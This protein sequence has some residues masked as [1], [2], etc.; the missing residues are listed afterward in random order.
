MESVMKKL[1]LT[2]VAFAL[3]TA[4]PAM[5]ADLA[6][7]VYRAPVAVYSWTGCY[8]GGNIGGA[9]ARQNANEAT[10]LAATVLTAPGSVTYS[11]SGVIGGAHAG[12]NVEGTYGVARG[13]VFGIEGDW[14][15]TKLSATQNAPNLFPNGTP[16]GFGSITF[17]ETTKSLAS[18]RGRAGVAVVPNVLLYATM[19]V[20]WNHTD[21]T[22]L[23]TYAPCPICSAAAFNS[24]NFGWVAGGG[25]EWAIGNSNWIA[26]AEGLYYKVSGASPY[27]T[28]AAI[29]QTTTTWYWN[30]LGIVVG[31]VGLSYKFGY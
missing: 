13:W 28:E 6:A 29:A 8:I 12:C 19:G 30:D 15:A 17:M 23:H 18:I 7:P 25:L 26:R 22:G 31:R 3:V 21:Y 2:G 16:I 1:L 27:G 24:N 11:T 9:S 4:G 10:L 20:V 5:A 14:S